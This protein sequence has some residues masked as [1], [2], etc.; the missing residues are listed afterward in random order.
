M[1]VNPQ[2]KT[3]ETLT[4]YRKFDIDIA[5]LY[6]LL[7]VNRYILKHL[8]GYYKIDSKCHAM[9]HFVEIVALEHKLKHDKTYLDVYRR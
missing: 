1:Y 5:L 8:L 9:K 4:S 7:K 2:V 6:L 3:R